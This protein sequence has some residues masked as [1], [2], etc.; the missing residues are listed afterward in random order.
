[1]QEVL[2]VLGLPLVLCA[3]EFFERSIECLY[4]FFSEFQEESDGD[5]ILCKSSMYEKS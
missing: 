5:V 2:I 4:S 1:M 3:I